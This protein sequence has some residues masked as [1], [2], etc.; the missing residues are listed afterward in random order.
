MIILSTQVAKHSPEYPG[1]YKTA[2][3]DMRFFRTDQMVDQEIVEVMLSLTKF[4]SRD[5]PQQPPPCS[6][7][8]QGAKLPCVKKFQE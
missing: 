5:R 3:K 8:H 1:S 4:C 2:T 7:R 6:N